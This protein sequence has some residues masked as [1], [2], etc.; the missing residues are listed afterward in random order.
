MFNTIKKLTVI[1]S[2]FILFIGLAITSYCAIA[3]TNPSAYTVAKRYNIG[4]QLTGVI[5]PDPDGASP[6]GFQ[7]VRNTYNA[8]GMLE[9]VESG[10]L[11]VW[12]DH[13]VQPKDWSGF[14]I[15]TK[16]AYTYDDWG[17]KLTANTQDKFGNIQ[18][19]TQY[20]YD[21][22]GRLDCEAVRMNP[23]TY[24]SLPASACTLSATGIYGKDRITKYTYDSKNRITKIQKAYGTALQQN[25]ATYS[26]NGYWE[27]E[28]IT[29]ANGNM[30]QH[31]YDG[32]GRLKRWVFPSKT[33]AGSLNE[34]DYEEYGYDINDNRTSLRKRDGQVIAYTLDN[35]N[36]VITKDLPGTAADVAYTYNNS[37]L[38]LTAKF[39]ATGKGIT[40]GYDVFGRI[41]S[42]TNSMFSTTRTLNYDYDA[43]GNRTKVAHPDGI[44]FGYAYD[45]LNLLT[46]VCENNDSQLPST[47]NGMLALRCVDTTKEIVS[48]T[49]DNMSQR[50]GTNLAGGAVSS[51]GYDAIDRLASLTHNL[52]GTSSDITIGF[53]SYNPAS[54]ILTRSISNNSYLYT[55]NQNIVGN[56]TVNG[57]NQYTSAGGKTF[58]YDNNSNLTSDGNGTTFVYDTENRL[59]SASGTKSATLKYDPKGRLFEITSA[60][61]TTQFLYDGDALV[62]EY[63]SSGAIT[64]RYVHGSRVDEPYV[65]YNA[66]TVSATTRRNLHSDHQGSIVAVSNS[67]AGIV[68]INRYDVYGI[69]QSTNLGRFSYTG[70]IYLPKVGLHYYKARIYSSQLGRFL[71][72]DPVGYEDQMNLY[73][74][75]GNDPVNM[76]DPTGEAGKVGW[77]IRLGKDALQIGARLS[78]EQAIKVRAAGGN[79]LADSRQ[80]AKQIETAAHGEQKLLK[81]GGHD[82]PNGTVGKP[83]FQTDGI[84]GHTFWS[85]LAVVLGTAA[86]ALDKAAYAADLIEGVPLDEENTRLREELKSNGEALLKLNKMTHLKIEV[87]LLGIGQVIRGGATALD[88]TMS[89][90][91]SK[92]YH[93]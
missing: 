5:N 61:V 14:V 4:G 58:A 45:G 47:S 89:N 49:Y 86:D 22:L 7:V 16:Q 91:G 93:L 39:I 35:L 90:V 20:S 56:Y 66:S 71:Q 78:K 33:Q 51:Y 38:E 41:T 67:T 21:S 30:A 28:N 48:P 68:G 24:L 2:T 74:Y 10:S 36:R 73:A 63:N 64:N 11:S 72:T 79:V 69:P 76:V 85:V 81:H 75:V 32:F 77:F 92:N 29:D 23:N 50:I 87:S 8:Q 37:N 19:L 43:N 3:Q 1:F 82:L 62:A 55:G 6:R 88:R 44:K 34:G 13:T 57:L 52:S 9:L 17:R 26:Y 27:K 84:K 31:R 83:H 80:M 65:W 42:S 54:Q 70:Q 12:Q 40:T 53:P 46:N 18:L 15:E 60:G 59:T 25:Y